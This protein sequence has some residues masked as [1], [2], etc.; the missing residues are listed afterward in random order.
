MAFGGGGQGS[1]RGRIARS[2]LAEIN[3]T[4]LVD[5]MLVLLVIFMVASAVETARV[6]REAETLRQV[7][8]EETAQTDAN[9]NQV[10]IDLPKIKADPVAAKGKGKPTIAIDGQKRAFLDQTLLV[11]CSKV[12]ADK[13]LDAFEAALHKNPKSQGLRD[14]AF[15]A[16]RKLDYGLVLGL[17]ARMRRAGIEHFGLVSEEPLK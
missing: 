11:D 3:V 9:E 5:V 14:A 8:T 1:S 17:M 16:D 12:A 13:C 15:R 4:P 6:A 10:P 2:T 7:V